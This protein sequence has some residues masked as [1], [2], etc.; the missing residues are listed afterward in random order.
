MNSQLLDQLATQRVND[1]RREAAACK[2]T[3]ISREPRETLRERAGWTLIHVGLRLT[4]SPSG[5]Q[6][7]APRPAG[8]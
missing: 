2:S 6:S 1:I 4:V 8:L 3:A 7:A 5:R